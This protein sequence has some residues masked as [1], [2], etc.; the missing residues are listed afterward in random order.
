MRK[1]ES[2]E[3]VNNGDNDDG[4]REK[5]CQESRGHPYG[6]MSGKDANQA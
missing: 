1:G 2:G 6:E 3:Y 4:P 5:A